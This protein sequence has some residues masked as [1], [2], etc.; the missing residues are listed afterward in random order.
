VFSKIGDKEIFIDELFAK[1]NTIFAYEMSMIL[2]TPTELI[3]NFMR[4][5]CGL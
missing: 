1:S 2:K 4:I 3:I 5:P